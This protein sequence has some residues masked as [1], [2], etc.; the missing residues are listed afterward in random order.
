MDKVKRLQL[1]Y[2]WRKKYAKKKRDLIL[3]AICQNMAKDTSYLSAKLTL[4]QHHMVGDT[5]LLTAAKIG[6]ISMVKKLL[7]DGAN[8]ELTNVYGLSPLIS[9]IN[10]HH[11]EIVEII[12]DNLTENSI[13]PKDA[14]QWAIAVGNLSAMKILLNKWPSLI[15]Q[16][17]SKMTTALHI[18]I[19]TGSITIILELLKYG[20]DFRECC[21]IGNTPLQ[22][23]INERNKCW[24]NEYKMNAEV[25]IKILFSYETSINCQTHNSYGFSPTDMELIK[26]DDNLLKSYLECCTE[27]FKHYLEHSSQSR[28]TQLFLEYKS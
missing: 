8:T 15:N 6:D 22:S 4:K 28:T 3:K 12:C 13:T 16:K 9:A 26:S 25:I 24:S 23:A 11:N 14:L 18:A 1:K 27:S 10:E 19:N 17:D 2:K 20:V 5:Y 7:D 21:P